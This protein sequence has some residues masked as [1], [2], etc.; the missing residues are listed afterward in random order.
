MADISR[1]VNHTGRQWINIFRAIHLN[2]YTQLTYY[3]LNNIFS[4][5]KFQK[6]ED[7]VCYFQATLKEF[8]MK[9]FS[10]EKKKYRV[11]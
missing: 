6:Y 5:K 2:F 10:E 9:Y 8:L 4:F 3:S 1:V 7:R 11:E